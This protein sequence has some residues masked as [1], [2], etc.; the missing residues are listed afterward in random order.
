MSSNPLTM[1]YG[2]GDLLLTGAVW[3]TVRSLPRPVCAGCGQWPVWPA[4]PGPWRERIRG[5]TAGPP[6]W[7]PAFGVHDDALYKSTAFTF[8]FLIYH[9][10][11]RNSAEFKLITA[12]KT[13][14]YKH[15]RKLIIWWQT[16]T[17]HM[18]LTTRCML[19]THETLA[20]QTH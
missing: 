19:D 20:Q 11:I 1:G 16:S 18:L 2:G 14:L 8:T 4:A 10:T 12:M 5:G 13:L 15:Q 9:H 3:P 6:A 7:P 17:I